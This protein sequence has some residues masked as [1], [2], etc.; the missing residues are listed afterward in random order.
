MIRVGIVGIGF[1]GK[2]HYMAYQKVRGAKVVAI[3]ET[4]P[5]RRGGDWST[6]KGNFGP[7]VPSVDLGG[8]SCYGELDE[9]L[10]DPKI[11]MIDVCLPTTGHAK[12]T[13]A[14][15][16]AGKNVLCEKPI[17]LCLPEAKKMIDAA[18]ASG[19]VFQVAH[20][21]PFFTQYQYVYKLITSG[22]YGK[23]LGGHFKRIIS[24]PTWIPNYFDQ[25][26]VGGP[27]LDL[28]VHDAHFIRLIAGMPKTITTTGVF[29]GPTLERFSSQFKFEDPT[30]SITATS[31]TIDQQGRPFTCGYEVYLEKATIFFDFAVITEGGN[32]DVALTVLTSDGKVIKPDLGAAAPETYFEAELA[33][34]AKCV[35][36]GEASPI[37][38][39]QLACDAVKICLKQS[40]SAAKGKPVNV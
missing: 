17:S 36:R 14:A 3:C 2:T 9:M 40:E 37:L 22:K 29:R 25:D 18:T 13:I 20:V 19:K 1:M 38:A 32:I 12:A 10:A 23:L 28:H 4:D 21:L 35:K 16:K 34:V 11:D 30:L 26:T 15:L 39:A 24:V 6:I 31:G 27:L 5:K 8:V 7:Y 33:E